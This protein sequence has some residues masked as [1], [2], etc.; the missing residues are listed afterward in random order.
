VAWGYND[1]GECNVPEPNVDFVAVA[2]GGAYYGAYSLGLKADG[3]I[4]AWGDNYFGQCNVPEPN[5]GFVAPAAGDRHSLGL[6]GY[7]LA[8]DTDCDGDVDD[9][10]L[11][12][13][14][15]GYGMTSGA[16]WGDGDF[17]ADGDVDLVDLAALLANYGEGT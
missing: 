6:K 17:D 10:D 4:V 13:L 7:P 2:A 9:S 16:T 11:L 5:T 12:A 15:D 14:L 3:S 8:G 1:W